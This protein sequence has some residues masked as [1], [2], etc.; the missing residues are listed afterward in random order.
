V[1]AYFVPSAL[2]SNITR[3]QF[4]AIPIAVLVASLRSW[5][6]LPVCLLAI[7]LAVSW[8][9]KPLARSISQ[10]LHNPAASRA[11][12]QSAI[13]FLHAHLPP[14]SRGG[15]VDAVAHGPAEYL[16]ASGIPLARGWFRQD[17]FP[18]NGVLYGRLTS[19]RYVTWLRALGVRYVLLSRAKPDY[20][21]V[22]EAALLRSGRSGL[23]VVFRTPTLTVFDLPAPA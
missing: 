12:W 13:R 21:A 7:A 4:V 22:G 18:G 14:S 20:S 8:N 6:P 5:R 11:Y 3:L 10:G 1:V 19:A 15:G 9:V 16:P 17:D 2:G 23:R